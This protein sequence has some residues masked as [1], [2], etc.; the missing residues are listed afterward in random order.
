LIDIM[1]LT[2]LMFNFIN[3]KVEELLVYDWVSTLKEV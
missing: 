1:V 3:W 2:F